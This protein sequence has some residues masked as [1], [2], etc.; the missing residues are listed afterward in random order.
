ME[1]ELTTRRPPAPKPAAMPWR[2]LDETTRHALLAS[3]KVKSTRDAL[4]KSCS[5][6]GS[7]RK[8]CEK[9]DRAFAMAVADYVRGGGALPA[10]SRRP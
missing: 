8:A 5:P 6:T 4:D 1:G 2:R 9:A 3:P 10:P 7:E